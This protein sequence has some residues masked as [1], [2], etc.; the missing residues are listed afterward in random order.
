MRRPLYRVVGEP[1]DLHG[2]PF[3]GPEEVDLVAV[4][5]DVGQ[6][7]GQLR[8]THELE[9]AL[10]GARTGEGRRAVGVDDVAEGRP[11]RVAPGPPQQFADVTETPQPLDEH[12]VKRPLE[13]AF[14]D[15]R[16]EVEQHTGR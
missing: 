2:H 7:L 1:I 3:C 4:A 6:G 15:Q 12:L 13:L 11:T 14:I 16:G 10:L 9:E 8:L 5:P